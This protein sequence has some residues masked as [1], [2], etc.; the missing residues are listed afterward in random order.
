V[1]TSSATP[2]LQSAR[3]LL[4]SWLPGRAAKRLLERAIRAEGLRPSE[5][6]EERMAAL[7]TGPIYR[8]LCDTVPAVTLRRELE[9]LAHSLRRS[10]AEPTP[11][12]PPGTN[13]SAEADAAEAEADAAA[14]EAAAAEAA[15]TQAADAA[16]AD[17]AE[18]EAAA[19]Q[20]A[21][22]AEA[23]AAAADAAEAD[24]AAADAAAAEAA[25]A[26]AEAAEARAEAAEARAEAATAS[27][28]GPTVVQPSRQ[29]DPVA[30]ERIGPEDVRTPAAGFIRGPAEADASALGGDHEAVLMGLAI[31]DGVDG[32]A[33]FSSVGRVVSTRGEVPDADALGRVIA[34]AGSLLERHGALRS[35]SVTTT[36]GAMV[37][38]PVA[39]HWIALRGTPDLNLGAVYAALSA[40]E[41]ER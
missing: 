19:T 34:A 7:L 16:E 1:K 39:P 20:A 36:S 31:L 24:A 29:F 21:D 41:E 33:V 3:R 14:A 30:D 40:L 13:A 37:A 17:A 15:A 28:Q 6:D 4:G 12:A 32:A 23:D 18:A 9:G 10:V 27:D 2:A 38:V 8:E 26:R 22:A 35:V 5:V 11:I 25:D